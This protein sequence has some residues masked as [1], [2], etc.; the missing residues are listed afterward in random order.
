MKVHDIQTYRDSVSTCCVSQEFNV[1]VAGTNDGSLILW[2]CDSAVLI[3]AI[4]LGRFRPVKVL[5]SR[6]WRFIV[7]YCSEIVRGSLKHHIFVHSINGILLRRAE[8][9]AAVNFWYSWFSCNGF[10]YLFY[11]TERGK[12]N[13]CEIYCVAVPRL[14]YGSLSRVLGCYYSNDLEVLVVATIGSN[15]FFVPFQIGDGPDA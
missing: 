12:W 9:G 13:I 3:R 5:V 11:S 6:C 2:A 14:V 1:I 15:V 10:D 7:S 8:I 4:E